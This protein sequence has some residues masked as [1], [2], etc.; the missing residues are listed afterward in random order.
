MAA[1]MLP[2]AAVAVSD[3]DFLAVAPDGDDEEEGEG[4][5]PMTSPCEE[6]KG[7][8]EKRGEVPMTSPGEEQDEVG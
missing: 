8:D 5:V 3:G 2:S 4:E 6:E 7:E 1:T